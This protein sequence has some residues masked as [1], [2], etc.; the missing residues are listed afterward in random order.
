MLLQIW[1]YTKWA[2]KRVLG[3]FNSTDQA[4]QD[5]IKLYSHV[6]NAQHIW[7]HRI[8]GLKP[9][10]EV[11]QLH[12]QADFASIFKDNERMLDQIMAEQGF[13]REFVYSN[14]SG[15]EFRNQVGD[16]L[17]QAFN[18]S[19]Y[20]RAQIMTLLKVAGIPLVGADYIFYVRERK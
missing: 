2:E 10:F 1:E 14:S 12:L 6:L 3:L 4:P 17:F 11:W 8:L 15:A 16:M 18:H 13:D 7:A 9:T 20:H 19:T 5:A